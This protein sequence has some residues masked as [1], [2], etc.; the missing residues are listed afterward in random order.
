M[1]SQAS[2]RTVLITG[3]AS[4]LGAAM[5]RRFHRAGWEVVI[6]DRDADGAQALADELGQR[7]SPVAMDVTRWADWERVRDSIG[8]PDALIN[9]AGVAV[10]GSLEE[11]SLEDWQWVMDIDLMGVVAGCKAF[12]PAMRERGRGHIF[13][14]ASFAGLAG[15]PQINAYGT[16]KA[17]VI[18]MSEMLRTELADAGV[19]VSVLCPA[20][21]RTRLTETMRAP[22]SSYHKRVERW[23]DSS[24]VS[25][26]DVSETVFRAVEK[27]RFLLLTHGN[28]RWLWRLKRFVPEFYFRM[29][30]RGVRKSMQRKR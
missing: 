21:V 15:A 9:N 13:N 27:P 24:G 11:T 14:V 10:G 30:M 18:A 19:H 3:A 28:T 17:G 1:N 25:P 4:G 7:A 23:M 8:A 6:A 20:F 22:D 12:A 29:M 16:A 5:A 26:E 2:G